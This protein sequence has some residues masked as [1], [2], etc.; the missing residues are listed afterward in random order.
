MIEQIPQPGG[1][2]GAR[3]RSAKFGNSLCLPD[4]T[5]RALNR[6]FWFPLSLRGFLGD[7]GFY[8]RR[9]NFRVIADVQGASSKFNDNGVFVRT[10]FTSFAIFL[11]FWFCSRILALNAFSTL[12]AYRASVDFHGSGHELRNFS[13]FYPLDRRHSQRIL[14]IKR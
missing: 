10:I 14:R 8:M 13:V 4:M 6:C 12:Y 3:V 1:E 5:H 9:I 2:Y 11:Q 7:P